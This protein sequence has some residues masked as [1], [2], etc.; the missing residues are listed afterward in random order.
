MEQPRHAG[1]RMAAKSQQKIGLWWHGKVRDYITYKAHAEGISVMLVNERHTSKTCPRCA[2]QHKPHGR[3]YRCPSC[4]IVA[5]RDVVGSVNILSRHV[6]GEL[7]KILPP[8]LAATMY[9]HPAWQGKRSRP[10]T[11]DLARVGT[12]LREAAAL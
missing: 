2:R 12:S 8:P 3:I 1:L 6:H 7:A 5:H 11:P 9:R 10:D 4:G